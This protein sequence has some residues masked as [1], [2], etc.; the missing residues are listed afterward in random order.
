MPSAPEHT[1]ADCCCAGLRLCSRGLAAAALASRCQRA[2]TGKANARAPKRAPRHR[3]RA[4]DPPGP[5]STSLLRFPAGQSTGTRAPRSCRPRQTGPGAAARV[6]LAADPRGPAVPWVST[7]NAPAL[8]NR[9]SSAARWA[10]MKI[11]CCEVITSDELRPV[12]VVD[13]VLSKHDL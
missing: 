1:P 2:G 4:A 10:F 12:I 8:A 9:R 7:D 5:S 11:C 6:A 13:F 3:S